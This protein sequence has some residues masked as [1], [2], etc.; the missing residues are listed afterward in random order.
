MP[1]PINLSAA[2]SGRRAWRRRLAAGC[3]GIGLSL[4]AAVG[5]PPLLYAASSLPTL[6]DAE[7][8]E[9][10]PTTERKLGEQIM[11]D[12]RQDRD[13]LDDE[14]LLDYLNA[15]GGTLVAA[16]PEVRG[17]ANFDF[18]FFVVRDP[19]INAFALPGGFIGVHSALILAAQSESQLASV[20]AHEIGHVTQ[21]H[22]ARMLGAQK[23]DALIPLASAVLA[24]LAMNSRSD[25]SAALLAGG[26][27]LAMQRQLNFSRDAEREADRIGL[28]IL[29]EAKFD[30]SGMVAFFNRMQNAMHGLGDNV[31]PYLLSHPMTT[32]RI[33]DIQARI[34]NMPVH[35]HVDSLDFQLV[36]ARL[37]VLQNPDVQGA[38]DAAGVFQTQLSD[39]GPHQA[40]AARY[41]LAML[42]LRR[43]DTDRARTL[44]QQ[45]RTDGP[46][47]LLDGMAVEIEMAARRPE[48]AL[49]VADEARKT[50]PLSRAIAYQYARALVGA[51]QADR[52]SSFLRDQALQY[53]QDPKLQELL[54]QSYSA[55]GKHAQEHLA[56]AQAYALSG[57]LPTALDQLAIARRAPDASYYDESIIDARERELRARWQEVLKET[58]QS[59]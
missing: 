54:A 33:A 9:L 36:R 41:G 3:A 42:A 23:Q 24:A 45:A 20:L 25:A 19:S 35:K 27:G 6:G 8:G 38:Q 12:I 53:K 21:R 16:R 49:R 31:P 30:T 48:D 4:A 34:R 26:Q 7:R 17:E 13:Y 44:L 14:P 50:W 29:D 15:F 46:S 2:R 57:S 56:L 43:G 59:P 22:I 55:Q 40:A 52:A 1:P 47:A 10:S 39:R 58:K 18:F 51:G 32:E 37:R 28:Q 5:A 11:R